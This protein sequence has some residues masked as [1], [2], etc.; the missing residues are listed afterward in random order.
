[1]VH[2]KKRHI[3]TSLL[4]IA[5]GRDQRF[6]LTPGEFVEVQDDRLV[7]LKITPCTYFQGH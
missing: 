5:L 7:R 6:S 4:L 3:S 1:L 2:R